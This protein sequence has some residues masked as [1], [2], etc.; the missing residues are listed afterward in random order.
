[1]L[2]N[3]SIEE[4]NIDH[5]N[6]S[7]V[8]RKLPERGK[9]LLSRKEKL[10]NNVHEAKTQKDAENWMEAINY[11]VETLKK[12][13]AFE[14]V[15]I[16]EKHQVVTTRIVFD[17]NL[18][19]KSR[20]MRYRARIVVRGF[21]IVHNLGDTF[22]LTPQLDT[23]RFV[24]SYCVG[25]AK[26]G[27]S[28]Y[29]IDFVSTLLNAINDPDVYVFPPDGLD[30][31]SGYCWRLKRAL[32]GTNPEPRLWYKTLS[33]FL[34]KIGFTRTASDAC[35]YYRTGKDTVDL[36]FFYVDDLMVCSKSEHAQQIIKTIKYKFEIHD[37]GFPNEMLGLKIV[38][39]IDGIVLSTREK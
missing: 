7:A 6:Y 23:L 34:R 22:A 32:Y 10:P 16:P 28:L 9:W 38:R 13:D 27:Y 5:E 33:D 26:E 21:E 8:L 19:K 24:I 11:E 30:K 37:L 18:S 31:K 29:A 2:K 14:E 1:M 15:K 39:S 3:E 12:F 35:L 4:D 36:I 20:N 25:K 17:K